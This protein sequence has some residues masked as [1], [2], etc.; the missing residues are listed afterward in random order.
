MSKKPKRPPWQIVFF[1]RHPKDD[2]ARPM[3][4]R[5]FLGAC[6]ENIRA[7]IL[8]VLVAVRDAPPPAFSGG[9]F[10][11]AMH[12]EMRGYYEIRVDGAGA[13]GAQ[14]EHYRLFCL[15]EPDDLVKKLGA[16]SIVVVTGAV[17]AFRTVFTKQEYAAV[18]RLG[19]E[20]L[21]RT[22][23]SVAR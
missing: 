11:E 16:P 9:G 21:K 4:G 13:D 19:D 17:K 2:P 12:D 23:R 22:P 18:R 1:Q 15:L 3:P 8:R 5:I 6:P 20:Y 10:W 7:R 14:R